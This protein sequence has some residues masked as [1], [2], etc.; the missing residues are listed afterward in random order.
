MPDIMTENVNGR[1]LDYLPAAHELNEKSSSGKALHQLFKDEGISPSQASTR[2]FWSRVLPD[3]LKGNQ[4]TASSLNSANL[5][6]PAPLPIHSTP[7]LEAPDSISAEI[8]NFR[9]PPAKR[10][11]SSNEKLPPS[12]VIEGLSQMSDK[13]MEEI[14]LIILMA[15]MELEKELANV[16]EETFSHHLGA[17]KLKEK[18][19]QEIKHALAK[20]EKVAGYFITGQ[21]LAFGASVICGIALAFTGIPAIAGAGYGIGWTLTMLGTYGP[22]AA[23]TLAALATG[24]KSYYQ[25]RLNE[26]KAKH[27]ELKHFDKYTS[28]RIDDARE[29]LMAIAESDNVFK[30][31]LMRMAK[32]IDK[33][34]KRVLENINIR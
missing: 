26:D 29:H 19:F 10:T 18:M 25:G 32:G 15:Q 11:R 23:G 33:M 12:K 22:M 27:E 2:S 24:S 13:T 3:W 4:D 20:D 34:K 5:E 14:M 1:Q 30:D 21:Q 9:L 17:H 6:S 8:A 16:A 7:V 31:R 28:D